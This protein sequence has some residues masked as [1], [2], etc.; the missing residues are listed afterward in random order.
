[1]MDSP[2]VEV[3]FDPSPV[4]VTSVTSRTAPAPKMPDATNQVLFRALSPMYKN[5]AQVSSPTRRMAG[6]N[7]TLFL[8]LHER[9]QRR[10]AG[11][12]TMPHPR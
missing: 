2:D 9:E 11:V 4:K 7:Q 8:S 3:S 1:M 12:V 5:D 10:S 6:S